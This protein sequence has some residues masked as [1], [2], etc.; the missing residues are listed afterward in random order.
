MICREGGAQEHVVHPSHMGGIL[1]LSLFVLKLAQHNKT[2]YTGS[3]TIKM[4]EREFSSID[5]LKLNGELSG[6]VSH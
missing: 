2:Y 6:I 5:K 1:L 3:N 4:Y